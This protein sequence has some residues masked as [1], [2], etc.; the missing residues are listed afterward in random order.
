MSSKLKLKSLDSGSV[1]LEF[2]GYCC[3]ISHWL[4][5]LSSY[6]QLTELI[7]YLKG[8]DRIRSANIL[9]EILLYH[10]VLKSLMIE[11]DRST[12]YYNSN[13]IDLPLSIPLFI[14]L[15]ENNLHTLSIKGCNLSSIITIRLII[16]FLQSPHCWLHQLAVEHCTIFTHDKTQLNTIPTKTNTTLCSMVV[17]HSLCLLNDILSNVLFEKNDRLEVVH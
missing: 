3:D 15:Q 14:E 8:R 5:Q 7:L 10:H 1:S 13:A 12:L 16:Q 6:T 4:S 11:M 2:T 17:T 9:P